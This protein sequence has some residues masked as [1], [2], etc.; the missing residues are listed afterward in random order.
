MKATMKKT[1]LWEV[2]LQND[3]DDD[4]NNNNN[5]I[6]IIIVIIITTTP[7]ILTIITI[8]KSALL[9]NNS[10]HILSIKLSS[11]LKQLFITLSFLKSVY[12]LELHPVAALETTMEILMKKILRNCVRKIQ[13]WMLILFKKTSNE[14]KMWRKTSTQW[15]KNLWADLKWSCLDYDYLR[16]K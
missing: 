11:D 13:Y 15:I 9:K 2:L 8:K 5:K 12:F 16:Y 3:D 6:L 1:P 7:T 4:N 14:T 10:Q